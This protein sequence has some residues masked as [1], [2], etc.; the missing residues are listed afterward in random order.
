M[1]ESGQSQ[2]RDTSKQILFAIGSDALAA[3]EDQQWAEPLAARVGSE[4]WRLKRR[5]M[6]IES[7]IDEELLRPLRDSLSRLEDVLLENQIETREHEGEQY[8]PGLQVEV[9]HMRDGPTPHFILETIL[10]TVTLRGR[11]LQQ[12]QVVIGPGGSK[13]EAT[14]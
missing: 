6:A 13:E 14:Q 7:S 4:V 12:G 2:P 10:P 9:L 1:S 11:V 8:D 5:L 3:L